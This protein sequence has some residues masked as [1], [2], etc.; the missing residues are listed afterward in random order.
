MKMMLGLVT[1]AAFVLSLSAC[2]GGGGSKSSTGDDFDYLLTLPHTGQTTCYDADGATIACAGTGQDGE[3]SSVT[4]LSYTDNGNG[5]VTDNVT[6]LIW[7]QADDGS[8]RDWADAATYCESLVLGGSNNWRL[9]TRRELIHIV[10]YGTYNGAIDGVFDVQWLHSYWSASSDGMNTD[11]AWIQDFGYGFN[12]STNKTSVRRVLCVQ[13]TSQ[14]EPVFVDNGDGTL[15][16][17]TTGLIWQQTAFEDT[18]S[19]EGALDYCNGLDFAGNSD[20]RLP[21]IKELESIADVSRFDPAYYSAFADTEPIA[22]W[23]ATTYA[24]SATYAW[25][26]DF[27]FATPTQ[28]RKNID[29]IIYARCVR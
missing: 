26:L 16:D 15:T 9:P 11:N 12:V 13:G 18:L 4:P 23:S 10:D 21:N 19:W 20:W 14:P 29:D 28:I 25:L 1:T 5:T 22:T 27:Y 2:G 8:A 24:D 17:N 3:F 7:Q 6:G